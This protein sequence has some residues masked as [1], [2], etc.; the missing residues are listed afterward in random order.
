MKK[1]I[2]LFVL[3]ILIGVLAVGC[4]TQEPEVIPTLEPTVGAA[5]VE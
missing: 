4:T 3:V 5:V 2:T 1:I